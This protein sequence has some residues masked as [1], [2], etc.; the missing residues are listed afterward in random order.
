MDFYYSKNSASYAVHIIL[1][2]SG[3]SYNQ[4]HL[5]LSSGAQNESTYLKINPKGR[6]PSI[7]TEFGILTETPAILTYIAQLNPHKELLPTDPFLFAKGQSFNNYLSSTVHVAHAHK[8][9]GSRWVDDRDAQALMAKKVQTNMTLCAELIEENLFTGPWVLG[10]QYTT[11]DPYLA[12]AY[13]W[14]EDDNVELSRFEALK[15]H[16]LAMRERASMQKIL[17][18]HS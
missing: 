3:Q 6:V 4:I 5:D 17:P 16:N 11:C 13:R 12:L 2:D 7:V 10:D 1:E 14:F 8:H 9:R 15:K 18:F